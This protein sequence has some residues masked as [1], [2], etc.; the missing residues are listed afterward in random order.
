PM[1]TPPRYA[2]H[3][4]KEGELPEYPAPYGAPLLLKGE[5][6]DKYPAPLPSNSPEV[7]SNSL[8]ARKSLKYYRE[9]KTKM[10]RFKRKAPQIVV[11]DGEPVAVILDINDYK[12]LLERLEDLED[13]E[14]LEKMRKKPLRFRKLEEFL[15]EYKPGV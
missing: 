3:P 9:V 7:E 11:R 6:G 5:F 8:R 12:K 4:F 1:T 13:L 10:S 15:E 14:L 2:R